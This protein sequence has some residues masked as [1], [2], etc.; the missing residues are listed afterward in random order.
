M[1]GNHQQ[2]RRPSRGGSVGASRRDRLDVAPGVT[3]GLAHARAERAD[4]GWGDRARR[5]QASPSAPDVPRHLAE[6]LAPAG[7]V[8]EHGG[9][10]VAGDGGGRRLV[11]GAGGG[12]GEMGTRAVHLGLSPIRL[13]WAQYILVGLH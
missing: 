1:E 2:R 7:E 8:G 10:D 6:G 13:G 5:R 11:V 3:R 4:G 12:V 9:V